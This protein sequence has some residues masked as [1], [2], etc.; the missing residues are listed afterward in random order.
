MYA[1]VLKVDDPVDAFA[2]HG[3]CGLWG[4]RPCHMS[5]RV[6]RHMRPVHGG[7]GLWGPLPMSHT[8]HRPVKP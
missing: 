1:Q 3:G 4:D 8:V 7:C 5:I 6:H 2:V